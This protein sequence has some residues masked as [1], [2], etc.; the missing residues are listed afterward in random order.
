MPDL[1]TIMSTTMR[2]HLEH[3]DKSIEGGDAQVGK[4]PKDIPTVAWAASND[5][6]S[7]SHLWCYLNKSECEPVLISTIS[8][9]AGS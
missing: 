3:P 9:S 4:R 8:L 5:N 2:L 1:Y 6:N 7:T